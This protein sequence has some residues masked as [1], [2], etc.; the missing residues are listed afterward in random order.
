MSDRRRNYIFANLN[1]KDTDELVAVWAK[2]D[3]DE[4]TDL[5]FDVIQEI[6]QSRQI[7]LSPKDENW[8]KSGRKRLANQ[9]ITYR[10]SDEPGLEGCYEALA[11]ARQEGDRRE[12]GMQLLNLGAAF[13]RVTLFWTAMEQYEQ[14]LAVFREIGDQNQ[15]AE[16]L[17]RL[18]Q[19]YSFL[20]ESDRA[21]EY[22]EQSL[23]IYH[24]IGGPAAAKLLIE[25]GNLC[26]GFGLAER[27]AEYHKQALEISV[28]TSD[29]STEAAALS[30]LAHTYASSSHPERA[31]ELYE[32]ALTIYREIGYRKQEAATWLNIGGCQFARGQRERAMECYEQALAISREIGDRRAEAICLR[33]QAAI[34]L[35]LGETGKARRTGQAA[36]RISDEF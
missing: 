4:W 22:Y 36:A 20:L 10:G 25:L 3:K 23:T 33:G 6:L 26:V 30:G 28:A 19:T 35:T 27:A 31:L 17:R 13:S 32:R 16:V 24:R 21:I 18:G 1:Q 11:A 29:H 15:E 2:H 7:G 8:V 9:G 14:A 12:E 34:F 5:A